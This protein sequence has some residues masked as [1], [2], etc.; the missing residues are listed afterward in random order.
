M[1]LTRLGG[2]P[3]IEEATPSSGGGPSIGHNIQGPSLIRTPAWIDEPLGIYSLYFAD[4]KGEYIRLAHADAVTGPWTVHGPGSLRLAD[5][6][7][8]TEPPE[9]T[10]EQL[11]ELEALYTKHLGAARASVVLIDATTPHIASPDVH[12]DESRRQVVMYFH[13]LARLGIQLTKVATSSD[14][15][16][17]TGH[18]EVLARPYVRAFAHEGRTYALAM[19]GVM[20]RSADGMTGFE[21]GPSLFMPE[22]RHSAVTVRDGLLH[23]FWTRVGDAPESILHSTIALD[24]DWSTWSASAAE[25]VLRPEHDWEGADAPIEPS[26]RSVAHGHVNQLR[27]PAVFDDVDGRSYLL[28][29]V[30]GESGIAVA[31]IDWD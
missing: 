11:S 16:T 29:A 14:G 8:I 6:T 28:Y 10:P 22:M 19:P 5:S 27:D 31:E 2:G 1:R 9:S 24:G 26:E 3:I 12:V 30:A 15:L 21:E 23:V 20:Y 25:V 17:F 13:G 7:L 4:H 18:P